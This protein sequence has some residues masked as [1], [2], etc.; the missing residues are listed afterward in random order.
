MGDLCACPSLFASKLM[1]EVGTASLQL[2][3]QFESI[4]TGQV[5]ASK[6]LL[7]WKR[8][9]GEKIL[10][11]YKVLLSEQWPYYTCM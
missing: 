6:L 9:F 2:L 11:G 10:L 3:F 7:H 4:T 1:L 5:K 8:N